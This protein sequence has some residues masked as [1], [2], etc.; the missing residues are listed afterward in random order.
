MYKYLLSISMLAAFVSAHAVEEIELSEYTDNS[1]IP[2]AAYSVRTDDAAVFY[3]FD[4]NRIQS[5]DC[6]NQPSHLFERIQKKLDPT[7]Q[8]T[9]LQ[10]T[11]CRVRAFS[12]PCRGGS[13][14][15][16]L[17]DK[18]GNTLAEFIFSSGQTEELIP[19]DTR[20]K[21]DLAEVED[22]L[23]QKIRVERYSQWLDAMHEIGQAP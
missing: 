13:V 10:P 20:D 6:Y 16:D 21:F 22:I 3:T 14:Y 4:G 7:V 2:S 19:Q 12:I 15:F 23:E 11:D 17:L 18:E 5:V 9:K 8:K 1:V